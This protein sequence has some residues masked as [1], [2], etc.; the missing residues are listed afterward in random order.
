MVYH[1]FDI[2]TN[3]VLPRF[4]VSNVNIY[5]KKT[6]KQKKTLYLIKAVNLF[7]IMEFISCV[8]ILQYIITVTKQK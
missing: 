4:R 2:Y 8:E 7:F 1:L 3:T 6:K 5:K